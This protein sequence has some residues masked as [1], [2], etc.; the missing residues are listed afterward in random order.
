MAMLVTLSDAQGQSRHGTPRLMQGPLIGSVTPTS[1]LIWTRASGS[2]PVL[3]EY[4]T[5]KDMAG[6][7]KSP[8]IEATSEDDYVAILHLDDLR[9]NTRYYYK[10]HVDG[11]EAN[12]LATIQPFE[13]KTAPADRARF[14]VGFGSCPRF[15]EDAVQPIWNHVQ[16]HDPDLF[17]W[18]GDNIY[19]DALDPEILAEEYRRQRTVENLLPVIRTTPQLATWDDHDYGLNDHDRTN[20]IKDAALTQ[21]NRYWANPAA[22]LPDVPGVFF[23]YHYGG[24]D[25][26]FLDDRYHR[27][28]N[29]DPDTPEKTMLGEGQM[30]W[31]RQGLLESDAPFKVLIS[32]SGW[33]TA[34]GPGGD[35]WASYVH[36]RDSLFG[37]I[38]REEIE[39]VVLLS[40]D[41]HVGE[42][43]AIPWSERGGYDFYDL[44]SSPLAQTPGASWL[45]RSPEIRIRPV[46]FASPNFGLLEF[47]LTEDDPYVRFNLVGTDGRLV[48]APFVLRASELKNGVESWSEKISP[49]ERRRLTR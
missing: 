29:A 7:Q 36:E 28:P 24:V 27:D 5:D 20:P 42:L 40:G 10:V 32:G 3:I 9:P 44:V 17:F 26:F 41:T 37:F 31:L 1:A 34:K 15:Q 46:F 12:Y 22:G 18:V 23:S 38:V 14:S 11:R 13:F 49:I 39:G 6:A 16:R 4:A 25:F 35:S 8:A 21:F 30:Q 33:S 48:W 19:G 43:N 47:N 45:N 2:F